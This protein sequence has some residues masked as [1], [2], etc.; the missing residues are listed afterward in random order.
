[1]IIVRKSKIVLL[2]LLLCMGFLQRSIAQEKSVEIL[3][4]EQWYGAAVA[5]GEKSP[6]KD[7]YFLN[8]NGD[9]QS[10]QAAPLLVSSRGR[11]IWNENAFAFRFAGNKI[12]LSDYT[13]DFFIG[14]SG[15]TLKDAYIAVSNKFFPA[16]GKSPDELL[17]LQPHY[18]TWIELGFNQNQKDVLKYARG[19]LDNGF[20]AGV[21]MIDD[22]WSHYFGDFEFRKDRFPDPKAMI[23]E[24]HGLGFKVMLWISPFIRPDSEESRF[25]E[26]RKWVVMDKEGSKNLS[27]REATNGLVTKWWNGYSMVMDFSN[28]D[29][30]KWFQD[31]LDR[32]IEVYGVD[33]FKLDGGDP[34][35]YAG[36]VFFK[37]VSQNDQNTLFGQ[38]G[39]RYSLN[40]YRT[41]WKMGGQ[42]I[43][44]RLRD[45]H[46]TWT[47]LKKLIPHITTSSL[48]G[49]PFTCCDM[50]GGGDMASFVDRTT[51]DQELIARSAQIH[52][53][54][55]MMQFSVAPWRILDKPYFDAVKKAVEIRSKFVPDIMALVRKAAKEGTPV[56][57]KMEYV[58]PNQGFGDCN[59]QFMLG[60]K[61]LVAPMVDKGTQRNVTLPKGTWK[62]NAGRKIKGGKK[63]TINVPL[64]E[65]P[66]FIKL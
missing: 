17:F 38:F 10:N 49:Y 22:N 52:A 12:V 31:K 26:A 16:S 53:L 11:Y 39:L 65:L 23:D 61:I 63:I 37:N 21:L 33:G 5:E 47:D 4:G 9:I 3:A 8:L 18:N 66:V 13:T 51:Y 15:S 6:F 54:M 28:P 50:I 62:D 60:D 30:V 29:A 7:G 48:L 24:L 1:M 32:L 58:F 35:Y 56:V 40:E 2:L 57:A 20:P 34:Q 27:H 64:D 55:P 45:K 44:E 25:L 19:L 41:N 59:D 42:P 14:S 36:G 46:H 43:Y